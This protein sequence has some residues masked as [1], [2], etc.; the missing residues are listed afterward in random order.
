[1]IIDAACSRAWRTAMVDLTHAVDSDGHPDRRP[2][3]SRRAALTR[4][5]S[6]TAAIGLAACTPTPPRTEQPTAPPTAP[7]AA[8]SSGQA[9]APAA[10]P[11]AAAASPVTAAASPGTSPVAAAQPAASPSPAAAKPTTPPSAQAAPVVGKRGGTLIIGAPQSPVGL[12][13]ALT[14]AFAS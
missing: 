13:P 7:P 4:L 5:L 3:I 1:M 2:V 14:T 9:A 11:A 10:S 6:A 8:P 12:D